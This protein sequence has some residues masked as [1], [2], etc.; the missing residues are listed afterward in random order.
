[1]IQENCQLAASEKMINGAQLKDSC[2]STTLEQHSRVA[3]TLLGEI[4]VRATGR[5]GCRPCCRATRSWSVGCSTHQR[6]A[7]RGRRRPRNR[8]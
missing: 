4:A 3:S 8:S 7:T 1:M 6:R 2:C 5:S